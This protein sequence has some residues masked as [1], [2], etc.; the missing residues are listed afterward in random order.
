M[1]ELM[2]TKLEGKSLND[3]K[4]SVDVKR[5]GMQLKS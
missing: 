2:L 1:G 3:I 4:A 5:K